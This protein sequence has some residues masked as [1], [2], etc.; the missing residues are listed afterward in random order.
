MI[1]IL[2]TLVMIGMAVAMY[3][4]I[5]Q[6]LTKKIEEEK[7]KTQEIIER[8]D[9]LNKATKEGIWDHDLLTSETFYNDRLLMILGYS[10]EDL[11]D[12]HS[13]WSDNIHP[14]DWNRVKLKIDEKLG[15]SDYV[16]QDEYRFRCKD[17]SYKIVNDRSYII[18]NTQGKPIRL[19]GAMNDITDERQQQEAVVAKK[20]EHK[21]ELG[22]AIIQAQE[23]EKKLIRTELHEDINQVLASIKLCF[24]DIYNGGKEDEMAK[25]GI[26]QLNDVIFKIRQLSNR[27]SPS[28]LEYF[29]IIASIK[30]M[31]SMKE[32][33][34]PVTINFTHHSFS[35]DRVDKELG[36][37]IYR[38]MADIINNMFFTKNGKPTTIAISIKNSDGKL[39]ILIKDNCPVKDTHT[40]ILQRHIAGIKNMLEMYNGEIKVTADN[41]KN[42]VTSIS[43]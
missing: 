19:I 21:N 24:H 5:T 39:E 11:K 12:N 28:G 41:D 22:K 3:F 33:L 13:W 38:V 10:K 40:L 1:F 32:N 30:D 35:E 27:L 14:D 31:I 26:A 20:L 23:E 16:W 7:I 9:T 6:R 34:Y 25:E 36:I 37:F 43:F 2:F 42:I 8:Y 4:I 18:R 17:G 29:G 15:N